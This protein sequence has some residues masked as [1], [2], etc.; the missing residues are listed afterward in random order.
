MLLNLSFVYSIDWPHV[1]RFLSALIA[2]VSAGIVT[3][4]AWAQFQINRRQYRLALFEKRIAV[5]NSTMN[6][7]SS[8]TKFADPSMDECMKFLRDTRGVEL[9]FGSEVQ[10]FVEEVYRKAVALRIHLDDGTH[11]SNEQSETAKW[12]AE[13]M[14]EARKIFLKYLDFREP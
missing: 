14:G 6:M 4:I 3:Y 12:C 13:Q 10:K 1:G 9:L 2:P 11:A 8:V 5:F 7:L